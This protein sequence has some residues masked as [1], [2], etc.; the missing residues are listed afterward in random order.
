MNY[1][2]SSLLRKMSLQFS[3]SKIVENGL[4]AMWDWKFLKIG[5]SR[6]PFV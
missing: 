2:E 4:K 1:L 3:I 5:L 6:N